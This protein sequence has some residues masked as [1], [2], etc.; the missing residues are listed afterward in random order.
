MTEHLP[1]L[2]S[3]VI[4]QSPGCF[5]FP[6]IVFTSFFLRFYFLKKG[7]GMK[8]TVKKLQQNTSEIKSPAFNIQSVCG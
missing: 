3:F 2:A 6:P 7:L 8:C 1:F 4:E 5:K